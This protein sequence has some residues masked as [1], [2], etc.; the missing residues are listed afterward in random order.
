MAATIGQASLDAGYLALYGEGANR[1]HPL[2]V[3]RVMPNAPASKV[4]MPA[5]N[6]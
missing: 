6:M 3:P 2:T 1:V 5:V 4:D